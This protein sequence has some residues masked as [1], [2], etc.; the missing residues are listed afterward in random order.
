[1]RRFLYISPWFPP[2]TRVG[3]MRPLKLC[4]HL[5][6]AGWQPVVLCD[7]RLDEP[8]DP[9]LLASLP[10]DSI[11]FPWWRP[12]SEKA[13]ATLREHPS[14]Q[15]G[16]GSAR[17]RRPALAVNPEWVPFGEHLPHLRHA[18][19]AARKALRE[20]PCEA[21]VV[22]IDP[23]AGAWVGQH[24]ARETGLPLV[25][26]FRDPWSVCELR[27]PMRPPP[28]RLLVDRLER[29]A[30][31]Q[32]AA[33][34]L[35]T[36]TARS[37]Y[38]RHYRDLPRDRF[39]CI[40]NFSDLE[41]P[42]ESVEPVREPANLLFLGNLR[43]FIEGEPLF[44]L[45]AELKRRGRTSEE[46]RLVISGTCPDESLQLAERHG[47]RSWIEVREPVTSR[48][49]I[50]LMERSLLLVILMNRTVQRL[51]A[52]LFEYLVSS[53]PILALSE[54][55]ELNALVEGNHGRTF[56]FRELPQAA[57]FVEAMLE[58]R[59]VTLSPRE[60]RFTAR[61]AAEALSR[62]LD[63]VSAP[64]SSTAGRSIP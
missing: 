37:H 11:V 40:R 38:I 31:D 44:A 64:A 18:L 9:R 51:P 59:P 56:G 32:A 49:M 6:A 10:V 36:E 24:L 58:G 48:E 20:V 21:I 29:R 15:R 22:S 33:I 34:V 50:A 53:R 12:G 61:A 2:M 41:P 54:T 8:M 5:P 1:M 26:D 52:K 17:A 39:H 19:R 42:Q 57:D 45:L 7:A 16:V 28:I 30:V 47:V 23:H 4:R 46:L 63:S 14:L 55:P 60:Q 3:A 35:N 62:I 27:R 25:L 13:W 43:R